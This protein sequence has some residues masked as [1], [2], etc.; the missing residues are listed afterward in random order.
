MCRRQFSSPIVSHW[1]RRRNQISFFLARLA[2]VAVPPIF[3]HHPAIT[4]PIQE[5]DTHA[6]S[7]LSVDPDCQGALPPL[8]RRLITDADQAKAWAL[9]FG[10]Y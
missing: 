6:P 7:E 5:I 3:E 2:S 1:L 9:A 8:P 4:E 10:D